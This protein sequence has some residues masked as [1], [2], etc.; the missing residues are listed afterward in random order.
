MFLLMPFSL[1]VFGSQRKSWF[2]LGCGCCRCTLAIVAVL[3][4]VE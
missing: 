1:S 2:L 3:L 4:L